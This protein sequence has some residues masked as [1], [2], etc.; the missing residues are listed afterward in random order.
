MIHNKN[1]ASSELRLSLHMEYKEYNN[2]TGD[3][4]IFIISKF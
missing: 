1:P 4:I 2:K 3:I